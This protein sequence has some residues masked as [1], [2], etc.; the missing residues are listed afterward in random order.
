MLAEYQHIQF[1]QPMFVF[2][3]ILK[4]IVNITVLF[5][6]RVCFTEQRVNFTFLRYTMMLQITLETIFWSIFYAFQYLTISGYGLI[7]FQLTRPVAKSCTVLITL[8]Y[9]LN[10]GYYVTI[11][12][13]WIN[14]VFKYLQIALIAF[15]W[16]LL[17]QTA[18]A[19]F[20]IVSQNIAFI[21][22]QDEVSSQS[23]R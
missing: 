5:T 20:K 19:N 21:K 18:L 14:R 9:I 1:M 7:N 13:L 17:V 11:D 12:M 15:Y 22:G 3:P 2:Y 10:S 16:R 23:S 8:S 4:V 6:I